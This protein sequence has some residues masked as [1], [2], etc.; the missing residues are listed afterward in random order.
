M[1]AGSSAARFVAPDRTPRV[2]ESY[3]WVGTLVHRRRSEAAKF[4]LDHAGK[5]DRRAILQVAAEDLHT[6]RQAGVATIYRCRGSRQPGKCRNAGPY[7]LVFIGDLFAIDI[8]PPVR[9]E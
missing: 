2:C 1:I 5:G 7:E 6:D 9:L 3:E 4:A 8:E